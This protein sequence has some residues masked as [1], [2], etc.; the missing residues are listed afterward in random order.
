MTLDDIIRVLHDGIL[1]NN[2]EHLRDFFDQ[3]TVPNWIIASDYVIGDKDRHRDAF[4]YTLY[5]ISDEFVSTKTEIAGK[6]PNDLK[7]TSRISDT[8][9]ECL[10]STRRFSFCFVVRQREGFYSSVDDI[11][12]SLDAAIEMV[13]PRENWD[14]HLAVLKRLKQEAFANNFNFKLFS[15]ITLASLFAATI[16]MFIAKFTNARSVFW[17]SDRDNLVTAYKRV[18]TD[19]FGWQFYQACHQFG[20]RYTS[21]QLGVGD[22]TNKTSGPWFD[23]L[24]RIPDFLA[25]AMS[26]FNPDTREVCTQ[27]HLDL[28][29]RVFSDAPNIAVIK[30]D[31]K[32]NSF[33]CS[34]VFISNETTARPELH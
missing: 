15:N 13:R 29:T 12:V 6:M 9:V 14:K 33:G 16:A 25:G 4:C 28:V 31:V 17:F 30:T 34:S 22:M 2:G 19:V 32:R 8:I 20:V 26:A 1:Q 18:A 23:E 21:V 5:P 24:I 27:K 3:N 7:S 10:R 11:R